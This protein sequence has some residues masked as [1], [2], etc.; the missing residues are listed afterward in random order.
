MPRKEQQ[1]HMGAGH[2]AL[3]LAATDPFAGEDLS[4]E[5]RPRAA[6]VRQMRVRVAGGPEA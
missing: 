4:R 3:P 5:G 2:R 6:H 1:L